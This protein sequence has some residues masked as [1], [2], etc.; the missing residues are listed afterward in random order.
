[1][2][3]PTPLRAQI[4]H[5]LGKLTHEQLAKLWEYLQQLQQEPVAALYTLHEYA[6][7]TGVSD[8]AEHHDLNLYEDTS[9]DG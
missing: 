8:L 2:S 4:E 3:T 7:N 1:M 6:I 9:G 5:A